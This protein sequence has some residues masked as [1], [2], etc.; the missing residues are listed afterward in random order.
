M[1][2]G[3]LA[4]QESKANARKHFDGFEPR[5][6]RKSAPKEGL[7]SSRMIGLI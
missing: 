2:A 4:R 5:E 1:A 7:I 3:L 6:Q